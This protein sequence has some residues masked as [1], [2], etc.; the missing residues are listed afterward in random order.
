[1]PLLFRIFRN[2]TLPIAIVMGCSLYFLFSE[3]ESLAPAAMFF[4]PVFDVLFPFSVFLTLLASFCM[5]DFH[6]MVPSRWN[7]WLLLVQIGMIA[8]LVGIILIFDLSGDC[9]I[10]CESVLTCAI[11]PCATASPVVTGKLGG[12]VNRM[13]LFLLVSSLVCALLIPLVFP[14]LERSAETSF[15][16]AFLHILHRL[17][18]VLVLP[19]FLGWVVRH[20]VH[21]LYEWMLRHRSLPFYLWAFSLTIT[22]GITVR[23]IVQSGSSVSV[24]IYIA[25]SSLALCLLLFAIG[26]SI[27][28]RTGYRIECGQG[29]GQKNTA[30]AIWM[31]SVYLNP[32]ASLGPGCYVLWQNIVN[33][34]ELWQMREKN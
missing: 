1:M 2:W 27:G 17:A 33:S 28:N 10:V 32:V 23:N 14:L 31:S 20:Y 26:W 8:V 29:M 9:R 18:A 13:T 12:N 34:F 4:G 25:L 7:V 11:G 22:S 3:V 24:L 30:M 21:P 6:K 19:L 5:V 16:G 15:L